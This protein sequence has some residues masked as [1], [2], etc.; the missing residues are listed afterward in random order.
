[1]WN[2]RAATT[3]FGARELA[4]V[5]SLSV[6]QVRLGLEA[7]QKHAG[8]AERAVEINRLENEADRIQENA[9]RRLF[10]DDEVP[11]KGSGLIAGFGPG[12]TAEITLGEWV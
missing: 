2:S 7:L 10:D 3:R 8:V 4:R 1:M 12:I 6:E 5:I 11:K 9:L